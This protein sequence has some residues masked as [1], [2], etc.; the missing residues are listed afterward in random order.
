M[1]CDGGTPVCDRCKRGGYQ[2]RDRSAN[3]LGRRYQT[4]NARLLDRA[5]TQ[6]PPELVDRPAL[7][8]STSPIHRTSMEVDLHQFCVINNFEI[9]GHFASLWSSAIPIFSN[10]E[11]C[12]IH[13]T[14]AL[15]AKQRLCDVVRRTSSDNIGFLRAYIKHYMTGLRELIQPV[16]RLQPEVILLC[17]LLLVQISGA[18][19]RHR[20]LHLHFGLRFYIHWKAALYCDQ[21]HTSTTS[22]VKR[23]MDQTLTPALRSYLFDDGIIRTWSP[24]PDTSEDPDINIFDL[25][26]TFDDRNPIEWPLPEVPHVFE[27][28]TAARI[29]LRE[30]NE[31]YFH[32]IGHPKFIVRAFLSQLATCLGVYENWKHALDRWKRKTPRCMHEYRASVRFLEQS[33]ELL[34]L[35][36]EMHHR[37][38]TDL[39]TRNS[40]VDASQLLTRC[41]LELVIDPVPSAKPMTKATNVGD[42]DDY[43]KSMRSYLNKVGPSHS[44]LPEF[45][46]RDLAVNNQRYNKVKLESPKWQS[47]P[48]LT[49]KNYAS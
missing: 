2:C 40:T 3:L 16:S 27:D 44:P 47:I 1:K 31:M 4:E 9:W 17:C 36:L 48:V 23:L 41:F 21:L 29:C 28:L 46:W 5:A 8:L 11:P 38:L 19:T 49:K 18:Q 14:I 30:I 26:V 22:S 37:C 24:L 13:L 12:V 39:Y 10:L 7:Q 20:H 35:P 33:H 6:T 32:S 25:N 42:L 45:H 43:I 15:G 34:L